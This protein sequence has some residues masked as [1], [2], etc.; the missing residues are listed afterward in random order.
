MDSGYNDHVESFP[1]R[2][3][4]SGRKAGLTVILR[5]QAPDTG[6]VCPGN[7]EGFKV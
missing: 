1:G 4:E 7:V 6:L 3:M 5:G 2:V